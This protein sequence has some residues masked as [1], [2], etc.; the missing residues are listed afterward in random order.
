MEW[1]SVS[2]AGMEDIALRHP[3]CAAGETAGMKVCFRPAD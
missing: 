1:E 3:H 2:L